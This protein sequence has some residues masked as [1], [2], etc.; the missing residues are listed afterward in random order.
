[1]DPIRRMLRG[2]GGRIGRAWGW[3][4]HRPLIFGVLFVGIVGIGSLAA[5]LVLGSW[6]SV[7]RDCP[8]IAQIYVW[9]PKSATQ[10]LDHEGRLISELFRE[11]RT[12]VSIETL[13]EYV[14]QG[15]IAVEDKR[16][17]RHGGFDPQGFLGATVKNILRGR[18]PAGGSTLTQQLARWMFEDEI[19]FE[20]RLTRKMKELHVAFQLEDVYSKDEILEAYIN[21]VNYG[22]GRYGIEAA[23]QYFFGKQAIEVTVP[24]AALLAAVVNRPTTYSPFRNPDAS[25]NRRNV[26]LGLMAEQGYITRADA[27]SYMQEP[28]PEEPHEYEGGEIAP[29]FKEAVRLILFER[30]GSDAVYDEGLRV[31]TTLDLDMQR[32]ARAVMDSGWARVEAQPN[33]R[34]PKFADVMAE[35]GSDGAAETQYLQGMFLAM[36]QHTGEIRAMIGG[37]DYED[38][39]FN[40]A[41]QALRQPGSTFKPIVY[42]AAIASGIPASRVIYDS[43]LM[44]EQ[45]DGTIYSP[46]NYEP[47]FRGPMTLRDAMRVSI[48]TVAVKL[49]LEVGLE[50]VSQLAADLGISTEVPPYP[51]TSIGA[52][53]V[54]PIELI[55]AYSALANTGMKVRPRYILKVEDA[56][57]RLL[58]ETQPE[59]EQ[60]ID[61]A[62]AAI[63]RDMMSTVINNGSGY[64]AREQPAQPRSLPYDV[65]AAGKTGTTNDATDVWFV[66]F[67]PDLLAAVWLG[68][69]RPKTILPRAA[70]GVYAAPIWGQFMRQMYYVDG[71]PADSVGGEDA[72][73]PKFE[74]PEPW[75]WPE[76]ISERIVDRTT[77]TLASVWCAPE[78]AYVEFFLP[79]TEPTELCRPESGL[80]GG[81]LRTRLRRDTLSVDTLIPRRRRRDF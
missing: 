74:M 45:V 76:R 32:A 8:S 79:G 64:P 40:R 36:D 23:S 78:D 69:D 46:R 11:R 42:T 75:A 44:L 52:A 9:E 41:T 57:G 39:K 13:P 25:R 38:S 1:M 7:C 59:R 26:V 48:N 5:G 68:F 51:S 49:G 67:T 63:A 58:W 12:P 33:F 65:P 6:K 66:G 47:E 71:A 28:L 43:P 62:V 61:T 27:E 60:V 17:Y 55:E 22:D 4:R 31:T 10:L 20:R 70:G 30:F 34:A 53:S 2:M 16:F 35:G 18:R 81:P 54:Y 50:T 56:E 37:R 3:L 19:G 72:P 14:P 21:Q 24:E 80:F 15:F 29:Y 73:L 77:G